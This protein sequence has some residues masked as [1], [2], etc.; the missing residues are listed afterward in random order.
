M[1][2]LGTILPSTLG[3]H[4]GIHAYRAMQAFVYF[5]GGPFAYLLSTRTNQPI[6]IIYRLYKVWGTN[7]LIGLLANVA[8]GVSVVITQTL[9]KPT[10]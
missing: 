3:Q 2:I 8:T 6:Y 7:W 1:L 9:R 10:Q 5:P 4:L